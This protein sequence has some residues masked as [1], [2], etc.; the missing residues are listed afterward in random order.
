MDPELQPPI[1]DTRPGADANKDG[2]DRTLIRWM[3]TLTPD[4]RLGVLQGFVDSALELR[5]A[6]RRP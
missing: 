2:V 1:P 3:L 5:R 4:E 6:A